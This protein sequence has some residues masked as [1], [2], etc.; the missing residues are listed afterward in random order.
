MIYIYIY[1]PKTSPYKSIYRFSRK[2][3][4]FRILIIQ[5]KQTCCTFKYILFT[6]KMQEIESSFIYRICRVSVPELTKQWKRHIHELQIEDTHPGAPASHDK[7]L[8]YLRVSIYNNHIHIYISS[9]QVVAKLTVI[10][11]LIESHR[12][13]LT[14]SLAI[15]SGRNHGSFNSPCIAW[16]KLGTLIFFALSI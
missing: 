5:N 1:T 11:R 2:N 15:S 12:K 13:L 16:G 8:L 9:Q 4:Q 3:N 6:L 10:H 7:V 14:A